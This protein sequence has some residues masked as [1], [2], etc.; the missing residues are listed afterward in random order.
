[1]FNG[2]H[3]M[4]RYRF[5]QTRHLPIGDSENAVKVNAGRIVDGDEIRPGHLHTLVRQ[6]VVEQVDDDEVEAQAP[7]PEEPE[8]EA[9][10]AKKPRTRRAKPKEETDADGGDE[11][12]DSPE[13]E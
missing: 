11:K 5:L 13:G 7:A 12:L 9:P 1:M 10:P 2:V 8:G 4:P 6:R 3:E